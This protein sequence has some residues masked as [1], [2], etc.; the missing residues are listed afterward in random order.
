MLVKKLILA[1]VIFWFSICCESSTPAQPY[2]FHEKMEYG[3]YAAVFDI[4]NQEAYDCIH[5]NNTIL[6]PFG[7]IYS[8]LSAGIYSEYRDQYIAILDAEDTYEKLAANIFQNVFKF[9][10][11][12]TLVGGLLNY[13][14]YDYPVVVSPHNPFCKYQQFV[15]ER[16]SE[17]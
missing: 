14:K 16:N 6:L 2:E 11:V 15:V 13:M 1:C 4:R 12:D 3:I 17:Q 10:A 8:M 7:S 5:I 9:Q